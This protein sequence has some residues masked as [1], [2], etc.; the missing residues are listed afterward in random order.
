MSAQEVATAFSHYGQIDSHIARPHQGTGLG[1]PISKSL[2]ELH[3]G[4]LIADS[5]KGIG[6]RITLL[7]P[8]SRVTRD[9][10]AASA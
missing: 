1:L 2:A 3:G 10:L 9:T 6:T 5:T 4:D 7:L 8:P